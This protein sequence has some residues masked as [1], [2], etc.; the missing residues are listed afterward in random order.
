MEIKLGERSLLFLE[1]KVDDL[2][3]ITVPMGTNLICYEPE[4]MV[5]GTEQRG[6]K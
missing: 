5:Q 3:Y 4:G 1:M 2:V 6:S